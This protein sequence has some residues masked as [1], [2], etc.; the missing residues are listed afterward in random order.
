MAEQ[1][2]F[3]STDWNYD[4]TSLPWWNNREE[5]GGVYDRF[6]EIPQSDTLCCLYSIYE[7]TMGND[8]G[9]LAVLRNKETPELVLTS[10]IN[11]AVH[12]SANSAGNL[13]FLHPYLYDKSTHQS[14]CPILILDIQRKRFSYV[15][16]NNRCPG[17]KV[18]EKKKA[19]FTIEAD[20]YQRKHNKELKALHGKKIRINWLKWHDLNQLDSLRDLIFR[21]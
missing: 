17:Y 20:E 2:Q 10:Q 6:Y 4:F 11:F 7:I 16:T 8:L 3:A 1:D 13:I 21:K 12:L 19:V 18:I 15:R 5:L 9:F 14:K